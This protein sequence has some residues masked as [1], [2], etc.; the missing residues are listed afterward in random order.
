MEFVSNN[1]PLIAIAVIIALIVAYLVTRPRQ[2][3][4]L[5]QDHVPKRPHM[6]FKP[7]RGSEGKGLASEAAAAATDVAGEI[8][9]VAAHRH[10]PVASGPAEDLAR[11]FGVGQ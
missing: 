7:D 3:V 5:S 8:L 6:A 4:R 10:L 9:H 2:R 11:L 1:L